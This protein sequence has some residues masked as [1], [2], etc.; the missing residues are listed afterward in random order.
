M[1]DRR[2]DEL[3]IIIFLFR[4]F[5]ARED[6]K[7][8]STADFGK[9]MKQIF[10]GIRPRRLGTRGN[11]RYC[12]AAMRKTT[13]L[14]CPMLPNLDEPRNASKFTSGSANSPGFPLPADDDIDGNSTESWQIIKTWAESLLGTQ[15]ENVT[16]MAE[17]LSKNYLNGA[18]ISNSSRALLQKKLLQR[19]V[20]GRKKNAL[21]A[22]AAAV[23]VS[24]RNLGKFSK[25]KLNVFFFLLNFQ[26]EAFITGTKK[27][28]KKKLK[29]TASLSGTDNPS[30]SRSPS[31]PQQKSDILNTTATSTTSM[32]TI[33]PDEVL[34]IKQE[35]KPH[36][37]HCET[38]PQQKSSMSY[39]LMADDTDQL[40]PINLK[41]GEKVKSEAEDENV[42]A[43]GSSHGSAEQTAA[44]DYANAVCKVGKLIKLINFA[45]FF[46]FI[47][48][49][50]FS[51]RSRRHRG[52]RT[53]L[54]QKSE[55]GS[56][57]QRS[58]KCGITI[59]AKHI[60]ETG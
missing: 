10:P 56:R 44:V 51:S 3:S 50:F 25:I 45:I 22:A 43:T 1:R 59:T 4:T 32:N 41:T 14:D 21:A 30:K 58:T 18:T 19:K 39:G 24:I 52:N 31:P 53:N 37:T 16:T 17:Y 15:F 2:S 7:P 12:Y 47:N 28:R 5:C 60:T 23:S 57:I 26:Q 49:H 20:K 36:H 11:S 48:F 40:M 13:K 9:V 8:L 38:S 29:D 33:V 34:Q 54:L 46:K 35:H 6:I 55:T 42:T 27:R